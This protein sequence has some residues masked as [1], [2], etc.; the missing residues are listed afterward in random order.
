MAFARSVL[1]VEGEGDRLFFEWLRRRVAAVSNDGSLDELYVVPT[2]SNTSFCPWLRLL[3]SYGSPGD[4]PVSW[5]ACPDADSPRQILDAWEQA[6]LDLP[7][8]LETALRALAESPADVVLARAANSLAKQTGTGIHMLPGNLELVMVD[9]LSDATAHALCSR[10]GAPRMDRRS[11][12]VWLRN[13]K[14][15]WMRAVIAQHVPWTELSTHAV[16]VL[17]RWFGMTLPEKARKLARS[18]ST[19]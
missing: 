6:S 1:L 3:S 15:P 9:G 17:E 13:H 11:L 12:E 8:D 16:E 5:L 2:G 19:R 4:R 18:P 14:A 7:S 10:V